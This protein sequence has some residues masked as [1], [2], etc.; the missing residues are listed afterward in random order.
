ME[1]RVICINDSGPWP[2][3]IQQ[4]PVKNEFYTITEIVR[5]TIQ[6]ILGCKLA[7][8]ETGHPRLQYYK[9]SRF[10]PVDDDKAL[11]NINIDSLLLVEQ[12]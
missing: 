1:T 5:L 4:K 2:P 8:I 9:L 7:E 10:L 12:D 6:G 3:G 11:E